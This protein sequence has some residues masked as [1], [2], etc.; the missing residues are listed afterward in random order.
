MYKHFG[1]QF[2]YRNKN[3][4]GEVH[5]EQKNS[6]SVQEVAKAVAEIVRNELVAICTQEEKAFSVRFVNGQQFRVCV[7]SID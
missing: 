5:M 2:V 3:I 7:E 6:I 1:A 4:K